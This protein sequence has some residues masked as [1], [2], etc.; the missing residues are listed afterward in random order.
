MRADRSLTC[1]RTRTAGFTL[2][3]VRPNYVLVVVVFALVLLFGGVATKFRNPKVQAALV[4]LALI[5][6]VLGLVRLLT[7]KLF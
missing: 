6:C 5:T 2:R 4:A 3:P 7:M 1:A